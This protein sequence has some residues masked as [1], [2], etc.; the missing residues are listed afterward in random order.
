MKRNL[1]SIIVL[2]QQ[3]VIT[4]YGRDPVGYINREDILVPLIC[5]YVSD[6][7]ECY[8]MEMI[9]SILTR[10]SEVLETY[11]DMGAEQAEFNL[12]SFTVNDLLRCKC[13]GKK[14]QIL[15]V[16]KKLLQK[17]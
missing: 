9:R 14:D 15:R 12:Y 10:L 13:T 7:L 1:S 4:K 11:S 8:A 5:K 2:S 17:E 3:E 16:Y 6:T